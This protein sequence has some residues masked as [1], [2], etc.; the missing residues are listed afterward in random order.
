M[1]FLSRLYSRLKR[2]KKVKTVKFPLNKKSTRF[3]KFRQN[4]PKFFMLIGLSAF[5]A[6]L[7]NIGILHTYQEYKVGDISD[8]DIKASRDFLVED[9]EATE[10]NR[11]DITKSII[12]SY[13]FDP[14][15]NYVSERIGEAFRRARELLTGLSDHSKVD[16]ED[17]RTRIKE[18]FFLSLGIPQDE[19]LFQMLWKAQF[20]DQIETAL[21]N[22]LKDIYETGVMNFLQIS[23]NEFQKGILLR[24]IISGTETVVTEFDRFYDVEDAKQIVKQRIKEQRL[25]NNIKQILLRVA[26][27][28]VQP[29]ITYNR[30]NT[31]IRIEAAR[32]STKPFYHIVRKGEIIIREGERITPLHLQKLMEENRQK[33]PIE[34]II[35][36]VGS[37][38]I[39]FV[40]LLLMYY[41]G[42][43][44][45]GRKYFSTKDLIFLTT[46]LVFFALLC[47]GIWVAVQNI[48]KYQQDISSR[49]ASYI[50]PVASVGLIVSIFRSI[51]AAITVGTVFCI[52]VSML[53]GNLL[54]MLFYFLAGTLIGVYNV[55]FAKDR[56]TIILASLKIGFVN[57]IISIGIEL[58]LGQTSNMNMMLCTINAFSGGLLS[59]VFT[60]G[61]LP[62]IE[63]IFG[64]TNNIKLIELA[65]LD[66]PLIKELMVQAPGTYHHSVIV[67]SLSE[68]AAMSIGAN[69]I[70]CKVASLYHDI[71]KIKMPLYFVENQMDGENRHEKLAPSMSALILMSHVKDGVE[72]A[73]KAKLPIEIIDII[74]QHHGSSLIQFF[75]QKAKDQAEKRPDRMVSVNEEDFRY[76]GP[77]PQT[78]E[79]A[80]VML[81]DAVEAASRSLEEPS[82]ARI[83]GLVH[84]IINR[85]FADGQLDDCDLTLK[86]LHKIAKTLNTTLSGIFHQRIQYPGQDKEERKKTEEDADTG[87]V[88]GKETWAK[89]Q[90]YKDSAQEG[91][92]RLGI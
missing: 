9:K 41:V 76:P 1:Q 71:G 64:Y 68:A 66:S 8:R 14:T 42:L 89:L 77:K 27:L 16:P 19:G 38:V 84:K 70:L 55:R 48:I 56:R 67:S 92:R 2:D 23:M 26:P 46:L 37:F 65:S 82:P 74:Q 39:N 69:P 15:G 28:L 36:L 88:S 17:T 58:Y 75:Y 80:V 85:I 24:N 13:D 35:R 49:L 44:K 29:N 83:K 7:I 73:H 79:A 54:A 31:M 57:V 51:S 18:E 22:V 87:K 59:G 40:F 61:L 5:F 91:L 45:R 72:M 21:K 81:S 32:N 78:K 90:A 62:I 50:L 10:R 52:F 30:R 34:I 60:T 6:C 20:N 86:D 25:D 47:L 33:R 43:S 53:T 11:Q 63:M 3:E 4:L 12:P